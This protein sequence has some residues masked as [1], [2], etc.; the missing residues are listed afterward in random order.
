MLVNSGSLTGQVVIKGNIKSYKADLTSDECI[1]CLV[2]PIDSTKRDTGSFD[3]FGITDFNGNFIIENVP[4]E[5]IYLKITNRT[6]FYNTIIKNIEFS[7][8][9]ILLESIPLFEQGCSLYSHAFCTKKY[10]WGLI[11][12]TRECP[13]DIEC[14]KE[15][16]FNFKGNKIL[17][18]CIDSVQD[19]IL[20]Q[21]SDEDKSSIEIQYVDLKRCG[22]I[23]Y[24]K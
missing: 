16:P 19:S 23:V 15:E 21:L 4:K 13:G 11:K 22:N 17:L 10:F 5:T 8:D 14:H 6:G 24:K 3:C 12:L 7:N 20:C 1:G 9:S 2:I 18:R